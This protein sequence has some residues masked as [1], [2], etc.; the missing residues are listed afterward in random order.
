MMNLNEKLINGLQSPVFDDVEAKF[1][2]EKEFGKRLYATAWLV[3]IMAAS[4]GLLIG[5]F[6][7]FDAYYKHAERDLSTFLNALMGALPFLLIAV[8]EP[9]KIPLAGG[10]Y[11]VKSIGWKFLIFI[12][13]IGLTTVTFETMFTGLER[14]LTNVTLTVTEGKNEIR[15]FNSKIAEL[16]QSIINIEAIN[17]A[18]QTEEWN[19][20]IATSQ[21]QLETRIR[22]VD[23]IFEEQQD[24]LLQQISAYESEKNEI[25]EDYK[26]SQNLKLIALSEP[27]N[28][29]QLQINEKI[30]SINILNDQIEEIRSSNGSDENIIRLND[31]IQNL[32]TRINQVENLFNSEEVQSIKQMQAIIGVTQD[33][34]VGPA[35]RRNLQSWISQQNELIDEKYQE[36]DQYRNLNQSN[37]ESEIQQLNDRLLLLENELRLLREN[38][39]EKNSELSNARLAQAEIGVPDEITQTQTEEIRSLRSDVE[40]L[41]INHADEINRIVHDTQLIQQEYENARAT[42]ETQ[43]T[44]Q[45][46]SVPELRSQLHNFRSSVIE[47]TRQL[48]SEAMTSQIYR[49]AQ[50]YGGY[51]DI[52]DVKEEDLSLIASIWFGS[53]ALICAVVGTILALISHIMT[54]PDAFVEKQK[55]RHGSKFSRS[56]RKL[57][58]A[59]RKKFLQKPKVITIEVPTEVEKEIE[60]IKFVDKE[61]EKIIETTKEVFVPELIP[62]PIYLREGVDIESEM[63]KFNNHY[64]DVNRRFENVATTTGSALSKQKNDDSTDD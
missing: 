18:D 55:N 52:L 26:S 45:K 25:I 23:D 7:A 50:K 36:I 4:L 39:E 56:L 43:L 41:R 49:F 10:L 24:D 62:I 3:E 44:E 59:L 12:S 53:I 20:K 17:I 14:Q 30:S 21:E 33:G 6:V 64:A 31:D 34:N 58:L 48:R 61:V 63:I 22:N 51:E 5:F 38:L 46:R 11:K 19:I 1:E 32:R 13:L 54:D 60:I 37:R 40:N 9:T 27:I 47:L 16:E 35:T 28:E 8:I 2:K 57:V 15:D 29:I 42:I